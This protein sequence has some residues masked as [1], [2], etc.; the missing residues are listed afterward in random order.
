[1]NPVVFHVRF[2]VLASGVVASKSLTGPGCVPEEGKTKH[3]VLFSA[4]P[5]SG[6]GSGRGNHPP[7][8][9]VA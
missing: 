7:H 9:L 6:I 3:A 5:Y 2:M 4:R 1:M 8:F